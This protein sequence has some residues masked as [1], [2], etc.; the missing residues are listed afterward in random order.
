[1]SVTAIEA[2]AATALEAEAACVW[3]NLAGAVVAAVAACVCGTHPGHVVALPATAG[4]VVIPRAHL[5]EVAGG[6]LVQLVRLG[7]AEVREIGSVDRCPP[8]EL[9]TALATAHAGLVVA[10]GSMSG[11][12]LAEFAWACRRHER[13]AILVDLAAGGPGAHAGALDAGFSLVVL[14]A[15]RLGGPA[16]GLVIGRCDLVAACAAQARGI[17]RLFVPADGVEEAVLTAAGR[18]AEGEAA[19]AHGSDRG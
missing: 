13:P 2:R 11:P 15:R 1:M 5:V 9:E 8:D 14:E 10:G 17:G 16:A 19:M 3:A 18:W 6:S 4:R 7:G 12:G